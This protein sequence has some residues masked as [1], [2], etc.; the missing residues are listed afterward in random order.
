[1]RLNNDASGIGRYWKDGVNAL[2]LP[3]PYVMQ[4]QFLSSGS[5]KSSFPKEIKI[6]FE[7]VMAT[8]K[9]EEPSC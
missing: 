2:K 7:W 9:H 8:A 4:F 1:M 6:I 5:V 3:S